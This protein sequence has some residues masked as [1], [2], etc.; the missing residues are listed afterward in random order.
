VEFTGWPE[1]E[2]AKRGTSRRL[3]PDSVT[4][5]LARR[6]ARSS[7]LLCVVRTRAAPFGARGF[8]SLYPPLTRWA[9]EFRP[10]CGLAESQARHALQVFGIT[11]TLHRDF[12]GGAV[13]FAQV[14]CGELDGDRA[15]VLV[16]AR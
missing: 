10:L 8:V 12:R 6:V 11:L 16:Q 13:D 9:N 7:S 1:H 15:D 2:G 5:V 3:A 14:V 4:F